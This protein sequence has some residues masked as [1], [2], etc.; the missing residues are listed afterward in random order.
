MNQKQ[1]EHYKKCVSN[2][3]YKEEDFIKLRVCV[4]CNNELYSKEFHKKP[5]LKDG[6]D[7]K[8]KECRAILVAEY[9]KSPRCRMTRKEYY[10][11]KNYN[12]TYE[13]V[14]LFKQ[15]RNYQCEIC[16]IFEK[17]LTT[18]KL[19]I[20]HDHNTGKV[21][22]LLCDNCNKSLGLL[23][24][25]TEILQNAIKYLMKEKRNGSTS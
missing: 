19:H 4:Q 7:K 2:R 18:R 11:Y 20:D 24:D 5:A 10:Y 15:Q 3:I 9:E 12:L 8:C 6:F 21:R 23:K 13:D 16:Y 17:D 25:S 1:I 22:G 14:K